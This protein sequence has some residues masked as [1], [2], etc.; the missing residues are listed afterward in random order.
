MAS[1]SHEWGEALR[2]TPR[3]L[4]VPDTAWTTQH[5]LTDRNADPDT[6]WSTV[7]SDS[8]IVTQIDDGATELTNESPWRTINHTSSCSA[9]SMVF[10]FLGL[11]A[12][13][14]GDRV[15]EIGAG[16]GW[17][18]ALLSARLGSDKVTTVEVDEQVAK[19]AAANLERAGYSPTLVVGDGAHGWP[20][21][22][23]YDRVHVTCGAV[24]IPY[25]WVEQTRPGGV[26][27]LP[28]M[29]GALGAGH[30][31]T[32][33]VAGEQAIGRFHSE[34]AYMMLRAQRPTHPPIEGE[35]RESTPRVDPRRLSRAGDGLRLA[36]AGMLPGVSLNGADHPGG[37]HRLALRHLLSESHAL[38]VHSGEGGDAEVTQ[39]GPRDLWSE[40]E[41]AYLAWAGW[42]EPGRGRFGLTVTP[43]GQHVW[44]DRPGN[45]LGQV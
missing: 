33:T 1:P 23:P 18:A 39:R 43:N 31:A 25:A 22:A 21:N 10:D 12:P 7:N 16:T 28:W 27:A 20:E 45:L 24:T 8:A 17:T 40:A 3:H 37:S 2:A 13:Y 41:A 29:H 4:F 38:A 44:L 30:K 35:A 11:L 5:G 34:C 42:G 36:L 32:L 14:P 26:I 19:Q 15:L 9:P 6:W